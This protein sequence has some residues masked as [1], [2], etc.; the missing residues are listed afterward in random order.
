MISDSMYDQ[1]HTPNSDA[2]LAPAIDL[3]K[4]PVP[5]LLHVTVRGLI[6]IRMSVAKRTLSLHVPQ[7]NMHMGHIYRVGTYTNLRALT[8]GNDYQL[9]GVEP[10]NY[11]PDPRTL[12]GNFATLSLAS[13]VNISGS[14]CSFQPSGTHATI[15]L[16]WPSSFK[17][18][19][20]RK[21]GTGPS[22]L[23]EF[24]DS[25][26]TDPK[27]GYVNYFTYQLQWTDRPVLYKGDDTFWYSEALQPHTV[28]HFFA[29]PATAFTSL[30]MRSEHIQG[31]YQAFNEQLFSP[32]FNLQ[33]AEAEESNTIEFADPSDGTDIPTNEQLDLTQGSSLP[34][35]G[36]GDTGNCLPIVMTD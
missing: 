25:G 28:L 35:L 1:S 3:S 14:K 21:P 13:D 30:A 29:D 36:G 5:H 6:C 34:K 26:S 32:T 12:K 23:F 19:R 22:P 15:Q 4:P 11:A 31:A 8:Y 9:E 27:L 33:E 2:K 7:V 18:L 24:G 20:L 16:P 17:R 10:G